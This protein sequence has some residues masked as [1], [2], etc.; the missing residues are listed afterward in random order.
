MEWVEMTQVLQP[1]GLPDIVLDKT[2]KCWFHDQDP[3]DQVQNDEVESPAS[4]ESTVEGPENSEHN[5]ASE[6]AKSLTKASSPKPTDWTIKHKVHKDDP[7]AVGEETKVSAAAHHLLPGGAAVNKASGLHKYMVWKKKNT[8]HFSGPIG[9]NI[10]NALNGIWLPG[11]YAVRKETDFKKNWSDF[12]PEFQNAYAIKA[13]EGSLG[14]Q[15]HDAH[16][17]YNANVLA[18]LN[19]VARKLDANWVEED[20]VCPVCGKDLKD[21]RPPPYGLVGRLNALSQEHKKP[22]EHPSQNLAAIGNGY[23]TSSRVLLVYKP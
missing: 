20:P 22:L 8:L 16:T 19:E 2:E 1:V 21:T 23:Y 3:Q 13:M 17:A 14:K 18:T 11:N 9:Y 4:P 7:I 6:L 12:S 15:L 5:D 10:N